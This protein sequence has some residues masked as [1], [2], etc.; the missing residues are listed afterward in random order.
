MTGPRLAPA[1]EAALAV[2]DAAAPSEKCARAAE[3]LRLLDAADAFDGDWRA[4]GRPPD[5]PSR[6]AAPRLAPPGAMPRRRLSS[7]AGRVALLHAVAHI[8]F[9]AIDL[10]FDMA[11]RFTA[12]LVDEGLDGRAFAADWI[13]VGADEAR[14]FGLIIN[15]L[16]ALDAAYGDLS[17]H[18]GLWE[19]ATATKNDP[20]ARLAIAPMVLEAR[21]LD[22]TPGMIEKLAGVGDDESAAALQTIYEDEIGHVAKGRIWFETLC[23]ARNL[24]PALTFRELVRR[25]FSGGLKPP[26]NVVG[27]DAAGLAKTYYEDGIR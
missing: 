4:P 24:S 10:A 8:E 16:S 7:Q 17:A 11:A 23:K 22:V 13:T 19:A 21:G 20:L 1:F 14:H 12:D 18:N 9:N 2:L 15:R 3:A 26:F 5:T 27:R 25:H 6:P